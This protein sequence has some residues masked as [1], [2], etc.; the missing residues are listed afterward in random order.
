MNEEVFRIRLTNLRSECER[1]LGEDMTTDQGIALG[2]ELQA[3]ARV[4]IERYAHLGY[5]RRD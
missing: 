3:H 5:R 2:A 1:L 4:I